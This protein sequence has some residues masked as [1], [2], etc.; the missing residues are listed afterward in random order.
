MRT[1]HKLDDDTPEDDTLVAILILNQWFTCEFRVV[2]DI[3]H[4]CRT[5]QPR[6]EK[7]WLTGPRRRRGVLEKDQP[8]PK[9]QRRPSKM[10]AMLDVPWDTGGCGNSAIGRDDRPV[11]DHL[12]E[13][14]QCKFCVD[15]KPQVKDMFFWS[16][17]LEFF[18][19]AESKAY[20]EGWQASALKDCKY[21][22]GC[23]FYRE[24]LNGYIDKAIAICRMPTDIEDNFTKG[25]IAYGLGEDCTAGGRDNT[26][27]FNG[28]L[29][30]RDRM[31]P[32][33][34]T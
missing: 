2:K 31:T 11:R 5:Y 19:F 12:A 34:Q 32:A 27:W 6:L 17:E 28:W 18:M 4:F 26:A 14:F 3:E 8:Y 9:G 16:E 29:A 23:G 7:Q 30:Q 33:Q 15:G 10:V 1:I 22:R 20:I 21:A 24:W 25:R 13:R